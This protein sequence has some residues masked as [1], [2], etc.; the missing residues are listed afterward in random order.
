MASHRRSCLTAGWGCRIQAWEVRGSLKLWISTRPIWS[1]KLESRNSEGQKGEE[2][3]S[4]VD[5]SKV[6][7]GKDGRK[8][9][10]ST[11][12]PS[13]GERT[14]V[15]KGAGTSQGEISDLGGYFVSDGAI[16]VADVEK[17]K[18]KGK[19]V[20]EDSSK[21]VICIIEPN[22]GGLAGLGPKNCPNRALEFEEDMDVA[23]VLSQEDLDSLDKLA[24][25]IMSLG[26]GTKRKNEEGS[27]YM[28]KSQSEFKKDWRRKSKIRC[29]LV[30][31]KKSA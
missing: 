4:V 10:V 19:G 29:F 30:R 16:G 8:E 31:K 13:V 14:T 23:V 20:L 17:R 21:N 12:V 7:R 28:E 1:W 9:E 22:A 11:L 26:S 3:L 24:S 15:V 5:K 6:L 18:S 27:G 2:L 25:P